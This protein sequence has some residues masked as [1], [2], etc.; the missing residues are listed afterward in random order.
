MP[1]GSPVN[2]A[3]KI[4]SSVRPSSVA[5]TW[6]TNV[7]STLMVA[8]GLHSPTSSNVD[9]STPWM[10][11][12]TPGAPFAGRA[13]NASITS[14]TGTATSKRFI[15]RSLALPTP[16]PFLLR[17]PASGKTW[18]GDPMPGRGKR[19]LLYGRIYHHPHHGQ[20]YDLWSR[21]AHVHDAD[22]RIRTA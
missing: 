18:M 1:S 22:V 13:T 19:I 16:R 8:E 20:G 15:L 9:W 4:S 14:T 17:P 5:L 12:G 21:S 7:P 10:V 2:R 11:Y 6:T 3:S